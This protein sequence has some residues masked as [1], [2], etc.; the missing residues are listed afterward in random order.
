[1]NFA[2][3]NAIILKELQDIKTNANVSV[4]YILPLIL[5]VLYKYL[6]PGMP[7]GLPLGMGLL[8]LVVLVGMYVPSMMIAEEKEKNTIEVLM[9]SPAKPAEVLIGKGILTLI[10]VMITSVILIFAVGDGFAHVDVVLIATFLCSIV[11]ILI[12]M[13]VGLVSPNQMATGIYGMPVYML[14]LLIPML[15]MSG[16]TVINTIAKVFPT[17]YFYDMLMKAWMNDASLM[18]MGLNLAV[19]VGSIVILS[20]ILLVFYR[21]HRLE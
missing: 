21:R 3:I 15:S 17:Y 7:K 20:V 8:F 9:L 12:G 14:L 2:R 10:S 1:M 4:M 11:A 18:T 5:A 19:L 6:I 16:N 13:M